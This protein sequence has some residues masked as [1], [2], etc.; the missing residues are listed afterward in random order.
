MDPPLSAG[1]GSLDEKDE[2]MG[3]EIREGEEVESMGPSEE[4][5][6]GMNEGEGE[7]DDRG[8]EERIPE[9][10]ESDDEG[11][12]GSEES[13][14]SDDSEEIQ[15]ARRH[16][17][18]LDQMMDR[19]DGSSQPQSGNSGLYALAGY[20]SSEE[21]GDGEGLGGRDG[22]LSGDETDREL[23]RGEATRKGGE[24]TFYV[25]NFE[26]KVKTNEKFFSEPFEIEGCKWRVLIFPCG[27]NYNNGS[28][29]TAHMSTYLEV[30]DRETLPRG[31]K[32]KAFYSLG[33]KK[34]KG[35]EG[36]NG[37][38]PT[39]VVSSKDTHTFCAEE[40]DRGFFS[41]S[42]FFFSSFFLFFF[43]SFLL[44]FFSSFLLFFFS[45]FLLFSF[46][47]SSFPPLNPSLFHLGFVS[48]I[49]TIRLI[50]PKYGYRDGDGFWMTVDVKI[51][52]DWVDRGRGGR[53]WGG[54]GWGDLEEEEKGPGYVGIKNQGATCYMNSMLQSLFHLDLFR[55]YVY[56][57]PTEKKKEKK[58][59]EGDSPSSSSSSTPSIPAALQRLF[60]RMQTSNKPVGTKELT[61]SFGWGASEV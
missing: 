43:S 12:E 24:H 7:S 11:S 17:R 52:K 44:S 3:R 36:M 56:M 32:R 51:H 39:R 8:G 18:E 2:E 16:E 28:L 38:L 61:R 21:M 15:D 9:S 45:S 19:W 33:I 30:Y 27:I 37:G 13:E 29:E 31:W 59:E 60:Y 46:L 20:V 34:Q 49:K 5:R 26:E 6:G 55:K 1:D 23:E 4:E 41:F 48:L 35:A 57:M 25:D 53:G 47:H 58:E 40:H 14:A 22:D 50:E 10:E 54:A 42:L